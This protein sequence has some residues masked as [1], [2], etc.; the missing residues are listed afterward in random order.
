MPR[1]A[2]RSVL[3]AALLAAGFVLAREVVPGVPSSLWIGLALA[4]TCAGALL[5]GVACRGALVCAVVLGA[6]GWWTLR[7]DERGASSLER[8]AAAE[9]PAT[10]VGIIAERPRSTEPARGALGI[11][12]SAPPA[13]DVELAVVGAVG[14][15]EV[16]RAA[17]GRVRV[18]VEAEI[19]DMPAWVGAGSVVRVGGMLTG[20]RGPR[21]PGEPD[22]RAW[23]AQEGMVGHLDAP[24][25]ELLTQ[26]ESD[27]R[28]TRIR[29]WWAAWTGAIHARAV[30]ALGLNAPPQPGGR[31][32]AR[33]LLGALLLG[34]R[35]ADLR[36]VNSAFQRLG[37][38]HLVAISGFNLAVMA[39]VA[40]FLL[41][42]P[43]ERGWLE[44][45]VI[46]LLVAGYMLVLPAQTPILRAGVMVL[47]L[48]LTEAL[49]RRYDRVSVLGWVAVIMLLYKPLDA[50]SLGFQLSF[51]I[52]GVLLLCGDE[53]NGR[54]FGVPLRGLV[55]P[56]VAPGRPGM[57]WWLPAFGRWCVRA[58]HMQIS[59][60]VLAWAVATPVILYHTGMLSPLAFA[61]TILV[62]PFT[63][64]VLWVG[65]VAL[66][67]GVLVPAAGEPSGW[68]LERLAALL[69]DVVLWID[70]LP[71]MSLRLPAISL[72][73]TIAGIGLVLY[74][75]RRGHGR[76]RRAWG[77]TGALLVWAAA[78]IMIGPRGAARWPLRMDALAVGEGTCVMARSD[79]DAL[80]WD[81]GSRWAGIG[82]RLVPDAVRALGAWRV[83]TIVVSGLGLE[84]C[85]GVVDVIDPL[86]VERVLVTEQFR[87]AARAD[88][89]GPE[90][91][92]IDD[93][94]RRGV[95]VET[96]LPGDA[97]V[98]GAARLRLLSP[99]PEAVF[100]NAFDTSMVA[101]I[102]V[103][104]VPGKPSVL[105]TSD[106]GE[107]VLAGISDGDARAEVVFPPRNGAYSPAAA[108]FLG[109][110]RA[111][112]VVQ[113]GSAGLDDPRWAHVRA[114]RVWMATGDL[115][116]IGV[117]IDTA[118]EVRARPL[119]GDT[120]NGGLIQ[121]FR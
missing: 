97:L 18:R 22:W 32:E 94:A 118:G 62:L 109:R 28:V 40:M 10:L 41:R 86:G 79:G 63:I 78:E 43:G 87:R 67:V 91:R 105:L 27:D 116:A 49:G 9:G 65:Y 12:S 38:I 5:R 50:W 93:I 29:G 102:E 23:A 15:D 101:R 100:S 108:E 26:A 48:L 16:V 33:A 83:R 75:V 82:E 89:A 61:T 95:R 119:V 21:N 113:S 98:F 31:P 8:L 42:L 66:L 46:A 25:W 110:T 7:I 1:P 80:L 84:H 30:D 114:G 70:G 99:A 112:L 76:D 19:A 44:P 34:E 20:V 55:R 69:V 17:S 35:D 60:S 106:V 14:S 73:W 104:G 103:E 81:C 64:I 52:V 6:A 13:T 47:A 11:Y 58:L 39:G 74:W 117:I 111:R 90:A 107:R 96:L 88:G 37:L 68:V 36:S 120:Q 2:R 71:A 85:A 45:T 59:A 51:G 3:V 54:M 24:G 53:V 77:L 92:M 121:A 115:G 56:A 72:L 57:F 4:W